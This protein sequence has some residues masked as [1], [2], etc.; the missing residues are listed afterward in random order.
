[1]RHSFSDQKNIESQSSSTGV[2]KSRSNVFRAEDIVSDSGMEKERFVSVQK[3]DYTSTLPAAGVSTTTSVGYSHVL[4]RYIVSVY[5]Y[6][7]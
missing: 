7:I 4:P 1:M 6:R 2:N 3:K 5:M